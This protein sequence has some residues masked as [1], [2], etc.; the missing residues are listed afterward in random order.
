[1]RRWLRDVCDRWAERLRGIRDW[2]KVHELYMQAGA[3]EMSERNW[4]LQREFEIEA[5]KQAIRN[6]QANGDE[7]LEMAKK[8][9]YVIDDILVP[10]YT[11]SLRDLSMYELR[12]WQYDYREFR[13]VLNIKRDDSDNTGL[14]AGT[15]KGSI[16]INKR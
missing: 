7:P 6:L 2:K 9:L 5:L 8:L 10:V 13:R 11:G 4:R 15:F 14:H 16:G 3:R 1:M 12:S